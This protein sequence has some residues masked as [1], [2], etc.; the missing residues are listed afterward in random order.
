M[1]RGC[2]NRSKNDRDLE[3]SSSAARRILNA[4]SV[5]MK[6]APNFLHR[7]GLTDA[8]VRVFFFHPDAYVS[9]TAAVSSP[10]PI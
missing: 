6:R 9:S 7:R 4:L 3:K 8:S 10:M 5:A 1:D 2:P